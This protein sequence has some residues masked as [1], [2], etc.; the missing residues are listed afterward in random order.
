MHATAAPPNE[1]G[2]REALQVCGQLL[3][4]GGHSPS[5]ATLKRYAMAVGCEVEVRFV[6]RGGAVKAAPKAAKPAKA[7][8]ARAAKPKAVKA[9]AKARKARQGPARMKRN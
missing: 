7:P 3:R 4:R 1:G 8:K 6:S 2:E 9:K 5:L